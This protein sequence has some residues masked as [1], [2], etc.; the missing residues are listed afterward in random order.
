MENK[1][2]RIFYRIS[3]SDEKEDTVIKALADNRTDIVAKLTD[4]FSSVG[5]NR[6][7]LSDLIESLAT[8]GQHSN[9]PKSY[10]KLIAH[11]KDEKGI[12]FVIFVR[13]VVPKNAIESKDRKETNVHERRA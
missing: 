12:A 8:F 11:F 3:K 2:I 10:Y 4:Y 6:T 7:D 1:P 9:A 5:V 13:R